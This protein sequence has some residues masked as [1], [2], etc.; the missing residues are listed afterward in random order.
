MF[1]ALCIC[2]GVA[3]GYGCQD[4]A[5]EMN[6]KVCVC[7]SGGGGGGGGGGG[8]LELTR[9]VKAC[10]NNSHINKNKQTNIEVDNLT[11][12]FCFHAENPVAN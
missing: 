10:K 4:Q 7:V 9:G 1:C 8:Y 12:C 2:S 6:R 5:L 11:F 3:K